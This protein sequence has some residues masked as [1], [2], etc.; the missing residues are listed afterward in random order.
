MNALPINVLQMRGTKHL[1]K[2]EVEHRQKN[3]IRFGG[4]EL[5]P[6]EQVKSDPLALQTFTELAK[7]YEGQNFV[8]S[9]DLGAINEYCLTYSE[10]R[11]LTKVQKRVNN[12]DIDEIHAQEA[13]IAEVLGVKPVGARAIAKLF[14]KLDFLVSVQGYLKID[15]QINKKRDLLIKLSDRLFLNPLAKVKNV[16]KQP[17]KR[18]E[19]PIENAGFEGV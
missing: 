19:D 11:E 16:G 13:Y 6:N 8:S 10:L 18:P 5:K 2:A 7:L 9:A 17:E 15:T 14:E 3:E 12:I 1:T 4:E